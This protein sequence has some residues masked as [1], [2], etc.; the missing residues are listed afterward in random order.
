MPHIKSHWK[1]KWLYGQLLYIKT[2]KHGGT[3]GNLYV[4]EFLPNRQRNILND[5][6]WKTDLKSEEDFRDKGN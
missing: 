6:T 3:I 4:S 1:I 5:N 2:T